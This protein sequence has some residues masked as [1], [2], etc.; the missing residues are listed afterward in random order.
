[1]LKRE[2]FLSILGGIGD[3]DPTRHVFLNFAS[4]DHCYAHFERNKGRY[5]AVLCANDV[6]A[7]SMIRRLS[8][9]GTRVPDDLYVASFGGTLLSRLFRPSLTTATLNHMELGRQAVST[10][11]YLMR[12]P[13]VTSSSVKVACRTHIRESTGSSRP[14]G[15]VDTGWHAHAAPRVVFYSDP[16]V[17]EILGIEAFLTRCDELD[18]RII[19]GLKRSVPYERM[20]EDLSKSENTVKYRIKRMLSWLG[21]ETREDLIALLGTYLAEDAIRDAMAIKAGGLEEKELPYP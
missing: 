1:M 16:E 19:D 8:R 10:F 21:R 17:N 3:A 18:L 20:A 15:G 6:V 14:T 13:D 2:C 5:D 9:A 12:N 7:V 4:M 11:A